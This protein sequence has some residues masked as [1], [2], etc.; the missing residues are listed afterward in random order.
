MF[1]TSIAFSIT[2]IIPF[3][4]GWMSIVLASGTVTLATCETGVCEP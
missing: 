4:H 2:G 1:D 3:S